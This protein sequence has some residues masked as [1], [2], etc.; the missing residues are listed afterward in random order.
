MATKETFFNGLVRDESGALR[1]GVFDT[2]THLSQLLDEVQ[3]GKVFHIT[4]RG[5]VVAELRPITPQDKVLK[6]GQLKNSDYW[7]SDDFSETPED[8]GEYQ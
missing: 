2:K 1:I 6:R 3:K 5:T 8:F 7:I 4:H